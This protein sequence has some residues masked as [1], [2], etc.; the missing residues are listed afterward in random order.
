MTPLCLSAALPS[1]APLWFHREGQIEDGFNSP[2]I[3]TSFVMRFLAEMADVFLNQFSSSLR[4]KTSNLLTTWK[5]HRDE[6]ITKLL[7]FYI[8]IDRWWWDTA[9]VWYVSYILSCYGKIWARATKEWFILAQRIMMG[10]L[11][12]PEAE[13]SGHMRPTVKSRRR[14]NG[15]LAMKS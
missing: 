5:A 6:Y 3:N 9:G 10:K 8:A 12:W 4:T 14:M 13:R 7:K 15:C 11:Q 2:A 1:L